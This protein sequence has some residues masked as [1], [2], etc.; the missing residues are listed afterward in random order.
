MTDARAAARPSRVFAGYEQH[1]LRG[2]GIAGRGLVHGGRALILLAAGTLQAGRL[3]AKLD[4]A[5]IVGFGGYPCVAPILAARVLHRRPAIVLHEQNAVLG[6]ANRFLAGRADLLALGFAETSRVPV[7]IATQVVGNPVRPAIVALSGTPAPMPGKHV[8]L[9][10]LGG[11][12][13]AR[14]FGDVVPQAVAALPGELRARVRVVQQC[15][16][17]DMDQV[18][19]T[20]ESARVAATIAPFFDDVA[21][22]IAAAHLIISRSGASTCAEISVAGR[23]A[24]LVP[25]PS[26]IDD[27]QTANARAVAGAAII[28]QAD[29][30]A[31]RLAGMLQEMV[32]APAT[33]AHAAQ[34]AASAAQPYAADTLADAVEQLVAR[35]ETSR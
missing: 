32:A 2:A 6:R 8:E 30:T 21:D 27:H 23:A 16:G 10:V 7:G 9:L 35:M 12:L 33:L 14:V 18:R 19:A 26:A 13:G 20:Y 5:A 25:L 34:L 24:I 28:P 1:V 17:E 11:S 4:A 22:R 15:R 29:F 3:L 31:E